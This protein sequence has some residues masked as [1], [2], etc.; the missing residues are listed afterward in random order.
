MVFDGRFSEQAG[1]PVLEGHYRHATRTKV[2]CNFFLGFC[3]LLVVFGIMGMTLLW[4]V[5]AG[6]SAGT[7]LTSA[8]LLA[9]IGVGALALLRG[10]LPLR[11][12]ECDELGTAI[13]NA[14]R[15]APAR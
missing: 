10:R 1:G 9:L 11:P 7:W 12:G 8:I 13:R 6:S 14:L 15:S 2:V 5:G 4:T 3:V